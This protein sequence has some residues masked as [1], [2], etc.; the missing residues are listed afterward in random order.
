MIRDI[1]LDVI[2]RLADQ[3]TAPL[4]DLTDRV[5]A[6]GRKMNDSL[7]LTAGL[8]ADQLSTRL[9]AAG[10]QAQQY[11]RDQLRLS[12]DQLDATRQRTMSI[13]GEAMAVGAQGYAYYRMLSP[14]IELERSMAKVGTVARANSEELAGMTGLA[15]QL[16]RDTVWT[17]SQAADGMQF[18]AMAG[19]SVNQV[20]EATPGMLDLA[21]AGTLELGEAADIASNI[22]TGFGL[23]AEE[24]GRVADVLTNALTSANVDVQMLGQTMKYVAPGASAL[25]VELEQVAAMAGQ[26]GDAGLQSTQAGTQLRAIMTR[27][28]APTSRASKVFDELGV[29]TSDA[30]GNLRDLPDIL[31]DMDHAMADLG[32]ATR[33]QMISHVFG[34]QAAAGA[35]ILLERAGSGALQDYTE[36]LRESGSAAR[37]AAEMNDT[38]AGSALA[39]ASRNESLSIAIGTLL[40][41][42]VVDMID[43]AIPVIDMMVSWAD[44]NPKLIRTIGW[45][46]AG[47]FGLKVA[48]VGVRLVVQSLVGALWMF[49]GALAGGIWVYGAA[50]RALGALVRVFAVLRGALP[51]VARGIALIGRALL[52]NPIGIAVAAIAGAAYLIYQNWEPVSAWFLRLWGNIRDIFGGF[53][54][55]VA[56]VFTGDMSGALD[57]LKRIWDGISGYYQ[58]LWDGITGIFTW[59]W[60]SGIKPVTDALG[61]TDGIIAGWN[62]V[63]AAIGAVLD[64]LKT[65]FTDA[66]AIISPII[67]ALKWVRDKGGSVLN[68]VTGANKGPISSGYDPSSDPGDGGLMLPPIP[69]YAQGGTFSPGLIMVG[70]RG[71][72]LRYES[73]GGFIAHNNALRGLVDMSARAATLAGM[74][75]ASG[76][77]PAMADPS[78][79]AIAAPASGPRQISYAPHYNIAIN[80]SGLDAAQLRAAVRA[81]LDAA[82]RRARADLR[83]LL[84]D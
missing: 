53:V 56:A 22:L 74:V 46:A 4:R 48:S 55:F 7:K 21:T 33:Q 81:E 59:A 57:A 65:A 35:T 9:S 73:R 20:L 27:L 47:L 60:E 49:R 50:A 10:R 36:A 45:L 54:Q 6:A 40:L 25:G 83:R 76:P 31:A 39:L 69:Q 58:T 79:A 32:T 61:I 42:M 15:R 13:Y 28:A 72:E 11:G 14:A 12:R 52:A 1:G 66:W 63:K 68:S 70:E 24:M 19:F 3:M 34:M 18:L 41:P 38:T 8:N 16:G 77:G 78:A 51:L 67:D 44:A 43:T 29:A 71:P 5:G 17:A 30:S 2:V 23:E 82:A 84:H 64:W 37:V 26:L 75:M 62:A 80:G